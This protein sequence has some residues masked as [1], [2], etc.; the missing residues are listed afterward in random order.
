MI[1]INSGAYVIPEF[2][3]EIGKV[4]PCLVPVANRK[5]IEHQVMSLKQYFDEDIYL[6]LPDNYELTHDE[7]I[8]LNDLKVNIIRTSI[9]FNLAEAILYIL[10]ITRFE[11]EEPIRLLHGDTLLV[12]YPSS[13][14]DCLGLG[15]TTYNYM[16][17]AEDNQSD[18]SE[19][20][21]GYFSFSDK[22]LLIKSLALASG[23]FVAAVRSYDEIKNLESYYFDY[24]YDF[25][26]INTYFRSRA[27]LTT[28]RAFNSLEVKCNVLRKTG[29]PAKKI[30]AEALWLQNIPSQLKVYTPQL[31]N[32]GLSD[33]GYYYNIEYLSIM[34]LNELFVHGKKP[35]KNWKFVFDKIFTFIYAASSVE[36]N[37]NDLELIGTD[38]RGLVI[39][40]TYSRIEQYSIDNKFDLE[41]SLSFNNITSP[42]ISE[43]IDVCS[44]KIL[45]LKSLSGVIHGDLCLSNILFNS[46]SE[47][48]KLIDPRGLNSTG[49]FALIGDQKYD[50][51]KLSHSIIGLYDFIISNRFLYIEKNNYE[52]QLEF[53][54]DDEI[55]KI[56]NILLDYEVNGVV[57]RDIIPLVILLFISMLPLHEDRKDRQKAMLANAVRLYNQYVV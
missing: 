14:Q 32:H 52:F 10:N 9:N 37:P 30:E 11:D 7:K 33:T 56:Q 20:W 18:S 50:L 49:E 47:Q 22:V 6:S 8:L 28:E 19:V 42:S 36:L 51:A 24:W 4:P 13:Q 44:Q 25:G 31:L 2:Q 27:K 15:S 5:L 26:H 12:D 40:K 1:I 17:E 23:D 45:N 57:I 48:I 39:D 54:I 3:A 46:R 43:I 53:Y 16:W 34:P 55:R 21:C 29:S 41:A 38:F 35:A